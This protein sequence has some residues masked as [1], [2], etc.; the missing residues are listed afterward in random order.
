[1][2]TRSGGAAMAAL[3][4]L[5]ACDQSIVAGYLESIDPVSRRD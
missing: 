4:K 5:A 2:T 1:M 3:A